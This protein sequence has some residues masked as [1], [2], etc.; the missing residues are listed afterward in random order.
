MLLSNQQNIFKTTPNTKI[1][2]VCI[3]L[4][5]LTYIKLDKNYKKVFFN[6]LWLRKWKL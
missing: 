4:L 6:E 5:T 3:K 2:I 1:S